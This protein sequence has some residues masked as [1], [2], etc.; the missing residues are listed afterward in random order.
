VPF[1]LFPGVNAGTVAHISVAEMTTKC[2]AGVAAAPSTKSTTVCAPGKSVK[3]VPLT[4]T[5]QFVG[6]LV[7]VNDVMVGAAA[8][9]FVLP[10][11]TRLQPRP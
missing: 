10:K 5:T 8:K 2:V 1:K 9:A 3:P 4:T 11:T 7:G 6:P